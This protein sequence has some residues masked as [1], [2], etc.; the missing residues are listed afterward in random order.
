VP[1]YEISNH[2]RPGDESRHNLAYWQSESYIGVGP[3][4]HGR[5][6]LG[7]ERLA[8]RTLKSPERW[9]AAVQTMGHGVEEELSL[10]TSERAEETILM[11]LRLTQIGVNL[12]VLSEG[13]RAYLRTLWADGR[14]APLV[15]EKLILETAN[16]LRATPK[17]QLVLNRIIETLLR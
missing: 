11:G 14:I 10:S 4:A 13:A 3:G 17:G 15:A 1:A 8:T 12:D 16:G 5:V 9:L 6:D 2:A 7:D